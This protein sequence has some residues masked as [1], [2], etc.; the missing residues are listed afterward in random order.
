M[1][2]LL[3]LIIVVLITSCSSAK[4]W[5]DV[6]LGSD[7]YYMPDPA[8]NSINLSNSKE[9]PM[10]SSSYVVKNIKFLGFDDNFILAVSEINDTLHYWVIDK[11]QKLRS[12]IE[13]NN[14]I[15]FD[16]KESYVT[17]STDSTNYISL[18]LK[19]N[20]MMYSKEHYQKKANYK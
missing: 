11:T 12:Q 4:Y 6:N 7:F 16:A 10:R 18:K 2:H 3:K 13:S 14:R 8:F 5:G 17:E 20:I 1:Q 19:M 15:S 9:D